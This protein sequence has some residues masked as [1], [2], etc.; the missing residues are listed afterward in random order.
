MVPSMFLSSPLPLALTAS[1]SAHSIP[2][3]QTTGRYEIKVL[4]LRGATDQELKA[5]KNLEEV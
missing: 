2:T 4:E 3:D 5:N 1:L